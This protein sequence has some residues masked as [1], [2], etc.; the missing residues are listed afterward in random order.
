[1]TVSIGDTDG[2][3]TEVLSGDIEEGQPLLTEMVIQKK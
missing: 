1:V 3:V 2:I